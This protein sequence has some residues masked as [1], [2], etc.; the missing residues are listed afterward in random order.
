[1]TALASAA[2]GSGAFTACP[3]FGSIPKRGLR[4][5]LP[6]PEP[7]ATV[8][9]PAGGEGKQTRARQKRGF[10]FGGS[11]QNSRCRKRLVDAT[12]SGLSQRARRGREQGTSYDFRL[13]R[14]VA[15]VLADA[16]GSGLQTKGAT[17]GV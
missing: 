15:S 1:M 11:F 13:E 7:F 16:T 6:L 3:G 4:N 12:G 8:T 5:P 17:N 2:N 14:V 9:P 10:D